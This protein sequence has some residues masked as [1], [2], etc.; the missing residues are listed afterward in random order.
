LDGTETARVAKVVEHEQA[1]VD[2]I[3]QP[4]GWIR[5]LV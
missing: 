2:R 4:K 5:T 1:G 3:E